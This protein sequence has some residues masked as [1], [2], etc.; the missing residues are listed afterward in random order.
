MDRN[1]VRVATYDVREGL[2]AQV[3]ELAQGPGG[4]LEIYHGLP[5]FRSY[6]L[7]EVDP[8]TCISVSIWETHDEPEVAVNE[9]A[10]WVATHLGSRIERASNVVGDSIFWDGVASDLQVGDLDAVTTDKAN[11]VRYAS[12]QVTE[13]VVAQVAESVMAPGG[14]REIFS[15]QPGFRAYSLIEVDPINFLSITIWDSHEEA[16]KATSTGAEWVATHLSHRVHRTVN[17]V[18]DALFWA[19]IGGL[20]TA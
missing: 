10:T 12:F 8:V 18:G 2:V 5:G 13:G 20:P 17:F 19:G 3:A 4:M 1:H 11:H 6:A 9:A 15:S 14:I 7:L 16:E